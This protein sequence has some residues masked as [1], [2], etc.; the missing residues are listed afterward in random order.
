MNTETKIFLKKKFKEYYSNNRVSAPA[1]IEKREFGMGTLDRKIA[2]RHKSF[3]SEN[4]LN[5]YL[6]RE[7]PYFI[8]YSAAYYEFPQNQPMEAKNWLGADLVFDIDIDM[9]FLNYGGMDKA[10]HETQKLVDF[11]TD[12][13]AFSPHELN[14]NFSGSK[15]YHIH[16]SNSDV[17]RLGK[18][19][20]REIVDYVSARGLNLKRE[21]LWKKRIEDKFVNFIENSDAS[22]FQKIEG[23]G[24]KTAK[25]LFERK[26]DLVGQI[27][28]GQLEGIS[29]ARERIFKKI[30]DEMKVSFTGDADESVTAD[31]S[32]LI[33]LPDTLHGG[34]GLIAKKVKDFEKF[35]PLKE[36]I[37]FSNEEIKVKIDELKLKGLKNKIRFEIGGQSFEIRDNHA[38]LPMYAGIY[39]MLKDFC[40]VLI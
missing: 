39:L 3:E 34:T 19:E 11:L 16:L 5:N 36:A 28:R 7:A 25:Q 29:G 22:D 14:I 40:D 24:E 30:T 32:K 35:D 21:S 4:E 12:D 37:A 33:R 2:V 10:K 18:D 1:E 8:S 6:R 13:F 15:G 17:L 27:K 26:N 9:K 23:I 20:R 31:T 38:A